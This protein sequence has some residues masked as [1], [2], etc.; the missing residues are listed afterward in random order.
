MP[1]QSVLNATEEIVNH[2]ISIVKTKNDKE[3]SIL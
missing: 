1:E 2:A 3:K